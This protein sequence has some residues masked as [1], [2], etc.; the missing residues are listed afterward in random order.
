MSRESRNR[1]SAT[2][3]HQPQQQQQKIMI[4]AMSGQ[5][6]GLE[7]VM[8]QEEW[9]CCLEVA[10]TAIS[11]KS[12]S[13]SISISNSAKDKTGTMVSTTVPTQGMKKGGYNGYKLLDKQLKKVEN[14]VVVLEQ[15]EAKK[16]LMGKE[17]DK[18]SYTRCFT[19]LF[20]GKHVEK[21]TAECIHLKP[22]MK[23]ECLDQT[24][25]SALDSI[26]D[27]EETKIL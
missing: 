3:R 11:N 19:L 16:V 12:I 1:M 13:I 20:L 25:A 17:K 8:I 18:I 15:E 27:L 5:H 26:Q 21:Y 2:S 7:E 10:R 6:Q 9:M 22:A 4:S 14:S 24:Y 23:L